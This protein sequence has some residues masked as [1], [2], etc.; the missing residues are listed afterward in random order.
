[1][2][3]K[4]N[5]IILPNNKS[6]NKLILEADFNN[7]IIN[8]LK[9]GLELF[10]LDNDISLLRNVNVN[11][12]RNTDFNK[13]NKLIEPLNVSPIESSI[14]SITNSINDAYS[15]V[16]NKFIEPV[17]IIAAILLIVLLRK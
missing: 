11:S 16:K 7:E 15:S 8:G 2:F 9:D 14:N 12:I 10:S 13:I 4:D 17:Y 3:T 1:M 6:K 5:N